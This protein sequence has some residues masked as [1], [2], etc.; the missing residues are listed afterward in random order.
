MNSLLSSCQICLAGTPIHNIISDLWGIISFIAQPQSSD[1]DSWSPFI[2]SS[3]SKGSN[4]ILHLPLQHL[5]L[6]RTKTKHLQSL[7]TISHHYELLPLNPKMQQE[8]STLHQEF[9]SSKIKGPG[10]SSRNINNL[11]IHCKHHIILNSMADVYLEDHE[12]RSTQYNSATI[13]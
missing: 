10:E 2:L 3:L 9:Q 1:Q 7:P 12:G 11:P 4:D 8:Y 6:R 13:T 5:S